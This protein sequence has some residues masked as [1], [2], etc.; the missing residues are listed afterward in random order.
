MPHKKRKKRS[1]AATRESVKREMQ[2]PR[3]ARSARV[4][5]LKLSS[6]R[7]PEHPSTSVSGT[8]RRIIPSRRNNKPERAQISVALA[9]KR[10]REIRIENSL[11]DEHGDEVTLKKGS[12]V[13]LTITDEDGLVARNNLTRSVTRE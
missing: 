10:Y 1:A 4:A 7:I 12:H 2:K 3:V 13:E 11:T 9:E 6:D 8:V 5:E